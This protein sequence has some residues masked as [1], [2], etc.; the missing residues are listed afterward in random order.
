MGPVKIDQPGIYF[1]EKLNGYVIVRTRIPE[2][3]YPLLDQYTMSTYQGADGVGLSTWISRL[4]FSVHFGDPNFLLNTAISND[5]RIL[6]HRN[7]QDRILTLAPFLQLDQDPY[8]VLADGKQ[9]WIQDAYITSDR[10]PFSEPQF[11]GFNYMRNSVK[12]VIDT[13]NGT[14]TF[15]V[16]DP[17][18]PVI[19]SWQ[20]IF[21]TL[22]TPFTSMSADLRAHV[23]YPEDYFHVQA[24]VLRTYHMK[25]P[26]SFYN[27]ED[28]WAAAQEILAD[29]P[30]TMDPYYSI[31]RLPGSTDEEYILL[32]PFTPNNKQNMVA[33]LAAGND[34]ANYGKLTL[35]EI[36]RDYLVYGP[37]QVDARISQDTTISAQLTLWSQSG[38]T[39]TRGNLIMIPIENSFLYIKSLYLLADQAQ[40]PQLKRVIVVTSTNIAMDETLPLALAKLY[41]LAGTPTPGTPAGGGATP[42]QPSAPISSDVAALI[43]LANTQ[44]LK[45]QDALK[46]GDWTSYGQAQSDLAKTLQQLSSLTGVK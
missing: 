22:F 6:M 28:Q 23:R 11:G 24:N 25:D 35:Y 9:Y 13:F 31:M 1:G 27:K 7:I 17:T 15:Y 30:Q 41:G 4:L 46:T 8:I 2:F 44:Y 45:A 20:G 39:V 36:P 3:D 26:R 19:R 18:D 38:S 34:G 42:S 12:V 5:S 37:I 10:Y 16:S 21:P 43:K 33:W 14:T 32:L 29:K 40:N